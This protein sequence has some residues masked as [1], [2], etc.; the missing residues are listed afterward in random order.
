L[1]ASLPKEYRLAPDL[2]FSP[3]VQT[4]QPPPFSPA[5]G[6]RPSIGDFLPSPGPGVFRPDGSISG[7]AVAGPSR[8]RTNHGVPLEEEEDILDEDAFQLARSYFDI[9]EFDR[10]VHVLRNARGSRPRFLRIYSA[11]LVGTMLIHFE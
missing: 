4:V 1:L 10:V 8:A 5:G 6:P 9:K 3:P 7:N 11:Y 2:T